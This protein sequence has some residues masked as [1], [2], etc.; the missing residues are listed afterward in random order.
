MHEVSLAPVFSWH[1]LGT[2]VGLGYLEEVSNF[3]CG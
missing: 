2:G 3:L 1:V